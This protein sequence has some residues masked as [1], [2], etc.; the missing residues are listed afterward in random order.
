MAYDG[1]TL[2]R[3]QHQGFRSVALIV[4]IFVLAAVAV[5]LTNTLITEQRYA[6]WFSQK[7][8]IITAE[9]AL[10]TIILVELMG[11]A[12]L[13]YFDEP[14][15]RQVGIA[16]RAVIRV[17]AYMALAIAIIS[18]LSASPALAVGVGGMMGIV[19]AFSTQNIIANV[20]AGMF[21][22]LGRPF[23]I[24]DEVT[25]M[26]NTGRVIEFT[27]IHTQIDVGERVA[28]VPNATILTQA[29]LRTKYLQPFDEG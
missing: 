23:T 10:F 1:E 27:I 22:A 3:P 28:L 7:R 15:T 14:D 25:V 9:V 26:G 18:L 2:R 21:I 29:I 12:V 8:N 6:F 11:R 17:V 16:V 24:G 4:A 5:G 20:F 19:I 13:R